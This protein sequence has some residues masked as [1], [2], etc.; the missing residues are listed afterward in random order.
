MNHEKF[1][2]FLLKPFKEGKVL[3]LIRP[4]LH[5]LRFLSKHIPKDRKL[6][7]FGSFGGLAFSGN[8]KYLYLQLQGKRDIRAV[9]ITSKKELVKMLRESGFEV[10]HR[11]SLKGLWIVARAKFLFFDISSQDINY[12]LAG[13]MKVNLWHG[14]PLKKIVNDNANDLR[15]TKNTLK[16]FLLAIFRPWTFEK[17][18]FTI[19]TS[20]VFNEKLASAFGIPY[21]KILVTG[22][23]RNDVFFKH[24]RG[25][26][27]ESSRELYDT[28]KVEKERGRKIVAYFPTFRDS[29]DNPFNHVDLDAIDK[30]F[31]EFNSIFIVKPHAYTSLPEGEKFRSIIFLERNLDVYPI[32]PLIDM[33]ITDYSS[34]YIDFVIQN[35]PVVFFPYDLEK[36]L[37]ER[38][39][40]FDYNQ[41]TPGP[42]A[43]DFTSLL[44]MIEKFLIGW[45]DPFKDIRGQFVKLAHKYRDGNSAERVYEFFRK[46]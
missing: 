18:D 35:R 4:I 34:I 37:K 1:R 23:P 28:L 40:Y 15:N 20:E 26:F 36:Y 33:L 31:T 8:P 5:L 19:S 14:M 10:Y 42:K 25:S 43:Y 29:G 11:N 24:I 32:L 45:E 21:D 38:D 44:K 17:W 6:W 2:S 30:L 13:G 7:V 12:W 41:F 46:I 22:Y 3:I 27:I 16:R 9:W 39:L